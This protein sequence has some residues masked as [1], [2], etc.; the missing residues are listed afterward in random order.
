MH[1]IK[2][3]MHKCHFVNAYGS[4]ADCMQILDDIKGIPVNSFER[5][6]FGQASN[7]FICGFPHGICALDSGDCAH[8][9]RSHGCCE[10]RKATDVTEVDCD[11]AE[12]FRNDRLTSN[13]L[14]Y[15]RPVQDHRAKID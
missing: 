15:H 12:G 11:G 1:L 8:L 7:F 2:V 10:F 9:H 3:Q 4:D 5:N 6:S 14:V 13:Q